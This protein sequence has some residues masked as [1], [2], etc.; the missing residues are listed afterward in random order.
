[1]TP[2]EAAQACGVS[3][4][5][6]RGRLERGNLRHTKRGGRIFIAT[7]D[8]LAAGL[9]PESPARVDS[10]TTSR[11]HSPGKDAAQA[12]LVALLG[13][14]IRALQES[15]AERGRLQGLLESTETKEQAEREAT[16]AAQAEVVALRARV[17]E[18]EAQLPD[19]EKATDTEPRSWWQRMLGGNAGEAA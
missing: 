2:T 11:G 16:E 8:L 18:L 12:D 5:A 4:R 3:E 10:G 17:Q 14:T 9:L 15:E 7:T 1:M 13:E 19:T 6:I